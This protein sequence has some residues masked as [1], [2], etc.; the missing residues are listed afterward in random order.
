MAYLAGI[1][2]DW[3]GR[4]EGGRES[5]P[6]RSTLDAI[7]NVL[8]LSDAERAYA[9]GLVGLADPRGE[10]PVDYGKADVLDRLVFEPL[11]V[12]ICVSDA[13]LTPITWNAVADAWWGLSRFDTPAE[14][15]F[16]ARFEDPF[17]VALAGDQYETLARAM[18]GMFRRAHVSAPTALSQ[19][20]LAGAM[21]NALFRQLWEE[22]AISD[23]PWETGGPHVREHPSVGPVRIHTLQL[24][25]PRAPEI[26]VAV[27]PADEASAVAFDRLREI[28]SD[29]REV[30]V[31]VR[32]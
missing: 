2:A 7:A 23:Q 14:R 12:G 13:Y 26:V 19:R 4:L 28:G 22:H 20:L 11:R 5:N 27:A 25:M 30:R 21:G 6:S 9:F 15:N 3:Y 18:V 10:V 1:S 31:A 17:I 24:S 16:V 8:R 29:S 32:G